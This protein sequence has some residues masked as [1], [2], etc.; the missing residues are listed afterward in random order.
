MVRL[1]NQGKARQWTCP[2]AQSASTD[3]VERLQGGGAGAGR[4]EMGDCG[5]RIWILPWRVSL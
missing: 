3:V 4:D 1:F 5:D 2:N